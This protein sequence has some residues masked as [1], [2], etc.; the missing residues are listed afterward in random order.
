MK[1]KIINFLFYLI[2]FWVYV[3]R[4]FYTILGDFGVWLGKIFVIPI[5]NSILWLIEKIE[6]F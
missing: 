6:K 1:K 4:F 5:I 2:A 3:V